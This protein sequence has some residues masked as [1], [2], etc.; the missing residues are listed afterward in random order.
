MTMLPALL[1]LTQ[2]LRTTLPA[3]PPSARWIE[4]LVRWSQRNRFAVMGGT[5]LLSGVGMVQCNGLELETDLEQVMT[6]DLPALKGIERLKHTFGV[7]TEAVY[8]P[9]LLKNSEREHKLEAH[10]EIARVEGLHTLIP[11]SATQRVAR[12]RALLPV[13][14]GLE[15]AIPTTL[16]TDRYQAGLQ[17][18]REWVEQWGQD[19]ETWRDLRRRA[20]NALDRLNQQS[21]DSQVQ[22]LREVI[23]LT[24][25]AVQTATGT[26]T[27]LP[28]EVVARYRSKTGYLALI[29]PTD[30]RLDSKALSKFRAAVQSVD[31]KAAGGLFVVDYLLVGGMDR[32]RLALGAILLVLGLFLFI[33]LKR[34]KYVLWPSACHLWEFYWAFRRPHARTADDP[35]HAVCL[36]AHFR[37]WHRRRC[38][39]YTSVSRRERQPTRSH[40]PRRTSHFVHHLE[41]SP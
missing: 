15:Q 17:T 14:D 11:A 20:L 35:R 33:D 3:P 39:H 9:P 29:Y 10:P 13:L 36:S 1:S 41:Y 7:S 21:L 38:P 19:S 37:D 6:R 27:N 5:L 32:M 24:R 40:R 31:P 18:A 16:D 12:N 8:S 22:T 28:D 23:H 2:T 25:T 30:T 26:E 34:P 4:S